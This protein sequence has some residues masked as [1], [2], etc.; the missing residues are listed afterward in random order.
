MSRLVLAFGIA[1]LIA[2]VTGANANLSVNANVV[3]PCG[4]FDDPACWTIRLACYYVGPPIERITHPD[5]SESPETRTCPRQPGS[6][7]AIDGA[8]EDQTA[9]I[10][11]ASFFE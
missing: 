5:Y 9:G 11:I 4:I 3:E 8:N 2:G 10:G 7:F 6:S 1:I